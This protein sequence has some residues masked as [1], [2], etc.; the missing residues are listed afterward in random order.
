VTTPYQPGPGSGER[1]LEREA[2]L[3]ELMRA[4]GQARGGSAQLVLIEGPA[5][6]GKS[7]LLA[8]TRRLAAESGLRVLGARASELERDFPFGIVRQ[9][10]EPALRDAEVAERCCGGAAAP[11]CRIFETIADV[12]EGEEPG[13]AV[14]HGLYWMAV[15]LSLE[16]PLA[17]VVD[18]LHWCDRP[19][20]RFLAYLARRLEDLRVLLAA[21]LRPAGPG[22][23]A[24]LIGELARDPAA[25]VIRPAPL[26]RKASDELI[27]DRLGKE[28]SERFG[29]AVEEATGGNPLLLDELLKVL[30]EEGIDAASSSAD[31]VRELG[32]RAASRSVLLRLARLTPE[33]IAVGRAAAVLGDSADI[34]CV[35][36][37]AGV[38]EAA[39]ATATGELTRAEIL[40]SDMRLAFVHPLV[41]AAVYEDV[42]PGERQHQHG[43][44]A[45][46]LAAAGGAA[47]Q[48]AA[49]MLAMPRGGDPWVV[50][51]LTQA[52]QVALSRGAAESAAT[53]LRRAIEEPP[54]AEQRARL[55]LQLGLAEAHVNAPRSSHTLR[56]AYET[57]DDP[58]LRGTAA[59]ALGRSLMFTDP[60]EAVV[61]L[62]EEAAPLLPSEQDDT[63]QAL[64]ALRLL[65]VHFGAELP[66][67]DAAF[68]RARRE[69][70][71]G[72]PG[73][74]MLAAAGA[75]DWSLTG[76]L[77]D[78]CAELAL[79]ALSDG[80]LL[81]ADPSFMT[82]VAAMVLVLADRDEA[83]GVWDA[84]LAEAHRRGSLF[85][86]LSVH[87][88]R[89][90]T[91][92]HRGE[93]GEAEQSMQQAHEETALWGAW[94]LAGEEPQPTSGPW[95]AGLRAGLLIERGDLAAARSALER[96]GF[97]PHGSEGDLYCL[98]SGVQLLLGEGRHAD[99]LEAADAYRDALG[100]YVNPAWAPWRSLRALA[101][102]GLGRTEDAIPLLEEELALA[103]RWGAPSAVGRS[104]RILGTLLRQDGLGQLEEA[105]N[106]L[107]PS[108]ARLE[109]G[110]ALAA[111][112]RALRLARRPGEAREPLRRALELASACEAPPL[113]REVRAELQAAGI[114]PR[115]EALTGSGALTASERRV[116]SLAAEGKTNRDIAQALYVTPK[117]V[118][119]HLSAAYRKLGIRSRRE[120]AGALR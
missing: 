2:E 20:L 7:R 21:T 90:L 14:L 66:D 78:E 105:I 3:E 39:A 12:I 48:V 55:L 95:V 42:P 110:K 79:Y 96:R 62:V 87:L 113:V 64:E 22:A 5:G 40:R 118:E 56:A 63:R 85:T 81:A 72:G 6:I 37:L 115:S 8:E 19:S 49:H 77:A 67:A 13:F 36:T 10:L 102:D 84:M 100:R 26:S 38:G 117:T 114:R 106:V 4:I 34:S 76:G 50:A 28:P 116:A 75:W 120:L 107:S 92:H 99:A 111:Y 58:S 33:A 88:W 11:A 44:A 93:L 32:P 51:T 82:V 52:A 70:R 65:A 104:L 41:Q 68:E 73:A 91:L 97:A 89:G 18:D 101:L 31:V 9:L 108:P 46:I 60:P 112:G 35:A 23:D 15:N 109:L 61:A 103:R 86:A 53:Y 16:A 83:L 71:G 29:V 17:V 98:R 47:E 25:L 119:V 57:I 74:R 80:V 27:R 54:P 1:L 59:T 30:R 45:R 69:S 24:A 94:T 43:R